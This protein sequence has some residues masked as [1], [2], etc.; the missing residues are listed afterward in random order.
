MSRPPR[1]LVPV[2]VLEGP[3]DP[4]A[5]TSMV[6]AVDVV[7]LGYHTVP[8]QTAPGQMRMQYEDEAL[9]RLATFADAY[10]ET[11]SEVTERLVFTQD[12]S[13]T[14]DRIANEEGCSAILLPRPSERMDRL[15]VPV[16]GETNLARLMAVTARL[17]EGNEMEAVLLHVTEPDEEEGA[18]DIMLRG[19]REELVD[20]GIAGDRVELQIRSAEDGLDAVV[21]AAREHDGLVLGETKPSIG[22]V[23]L[24][25]AHERIAEAYDGPILI[26]RRELEGEVPPVPEDA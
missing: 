22:D 7:L 13:D 12:A 9:E 3:P 16:R 20:A 1:V 10:R 17:L 24:G 21:E 23:V 18:G 15:L 19:A 11:G 8:E 5:T 14:F 25:E 26:V 2:D 4:G 6:A